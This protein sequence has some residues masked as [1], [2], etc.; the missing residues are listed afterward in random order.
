VLSLVGLLAVGFAL[1]LSGTAIA[2]RFMYK[3]ARR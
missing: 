2:T 3:M 1:F